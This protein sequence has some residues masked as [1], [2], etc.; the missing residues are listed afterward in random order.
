M[1]RRL[2]LPLVL[3]I[4]ALSMMAAAPAYAAALSIE[5]HS[6]A[7]IYGQWSLTLPSGTTL[8][9]N[10]AEETRTIVNPAAGTYTI[11][12]QPPDGATTT[13]RYLQNGTTT[14]SVTDKHLT[15]TLEASDEAKIQIAFTYQGSITIESTPSGAPF[16][17]STTTGFHRTG[18][19]P[20]TFHELPPFTYAVNF[21]LMEGCSVPRPA[22]RTLAANASV[23]FTGVYVCSSGHTSSASN[24]RSSRS[25]SSSLS[26]SVSSA[27][28]SARVIHRI[29][30]MEVLPGGSVRVTV[31]IVNTS[32]STLHDLVLSEQ[33]DP[34]AVTV[35]NIQNDGSLDDGL[36]VWNIPTIL[37]TQR[38]SATFIAHVR[39]DV[40]S[41]DHITLTARASG[42]E[43]DRTAEDQRMSTVSLGVAHMPTTGGAWDVLFALLG[44]LVPAPIVIAQRR[45][46]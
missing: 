42:D 23:V 41:G 17:I 2:R 20:E 10:G 37:A 46:K 6:D 18:S 27:M 22:K 25:S 16:D 36:I 35:D 5:Q 11:I 30:Q 15:F 7:A 32:R 19:A 1:L 39:D 12:V 3:P 33:F 8:A 4:V 14:K 40:V 38:W 13:I 34:G 29:E 31:G 28:G 21:G 44:L 24:S 9:S 43:L 26:S 45:A